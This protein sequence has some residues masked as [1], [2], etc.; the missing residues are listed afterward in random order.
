MRWIG[1]RPCS[2]NC[3]LQTRCTCKTIAKSILQ[4]K[5]L[6][7]KLPESVFNS[8]LMLNAKPIDARRPILAFLKFKI[9]ESTDLVLFVERKGCDIYKVNL[10]IVQRH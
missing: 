5:L 9:L 8:N 10:N 4:E 3:E 2:F 6:A 1:H 7:K